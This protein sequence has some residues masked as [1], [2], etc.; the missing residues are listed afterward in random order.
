[1]DFLKE[2]DFN[3]FFKPKTIA[4]IGA[5][6][7]PGKIGNQIVVNLQMN[8]DI[9]I[10]PINPKSERICGLITYSSI[11]S[12][13]KKVDLV[14]IAVPAMIVNTILVECGENGIKNCIVISAGFSEVKGEGI[15]I[16]K[17]LKEIAQKYSMTILGPN[18]LGIISPETK[19]NASFGDMGKNGNVIFISQSGALGT[20]ILDWAKNQNIGFSKFISLGNKAVVSEIE[21]LEYFSK[22]K[23][24]HIIAL[25]VESINNGQKFLKVIKKLSKK[26]KVI[27]LKG[28]QEKETGDA[29]TSHTGAMAGSFSVFQ[30]ALRQA[31]CIEATNLEE[32]F[33]LIKI[34]SI[35]KQIKGKRIVL[36][37]NGGGPGI[38][39][40][41]M[42]I[43][44]KNTPAVINSE[45][46]EQLVKILPKESSVAN[47]IDLLGDA[48]PQRYKDVL[49]ILVK[50]T[51]NDTIIV[52]LT[53]QKAT[54]TVNIAREIVKIQKKTNKLIITSFI[55]GMRIEEAKKILQEG[56]VVNFLYP[57]QAL[58]VLHK[59]S[60]Y[61][62]KRYKHEKQTPIQWNH[63]I[64]NNYLKNVL[65]EKREKLYDNESYLILDKYSIPHPKT[66]K[67]DSVS[68]F[69]RIFK[70]IHFPVAL[71][72]D[73]PRI[74]HKNQENA[75]FLN[76]ETIREAK[77]VFSKLRKM[78]GTIYCQEM[79]PHGLEVIIGAIKDPDFGHIIM[80]GTGGIYTEYLK[81]VA[82]AVVPLSVNDAEELIDQTKV[83]TELGKSRKSIIKI[84]LTVSK[85]LMENPAISKFDINP[86][87]ISKNNINA[88][89]I[90]IQVSVPE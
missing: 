85:L 42:I 27:V 67:V 21:L 73:S 77:V 1:M 86:L 49:E 7:D 53:P 43:Q 54:D 36:M 50:E 69:E 78:E 32:F 35:Q 25:Y 47:P 24:N 61:H 14:I 84:I 68:S 13:K 28:G 46:K 38:L 71:K 33:S 66:I 55:G 41:D 57:E 88:V 83:A 79:I 72:L 8:K 52:L 90:K 39:T 4:V 15:S 74:Y 30:A 22:Q 48:T 17:E 89:D 9:E 20:A 65:V 62:E 70:S 18:C 87:I 34:L 19:V 75:L 37:T 80:F 44:T 23:E 5:S 63:K 58:K 3:N 29:V 6:H 2:V 40:M 59:I 64:I 81:D 11:S 16:E 82:F 51:S 31:N 26:T 12:V 10:I 45:V 56:D 60:R 76:I